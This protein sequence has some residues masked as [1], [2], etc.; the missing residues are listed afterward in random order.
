MFSLAATQTP[1]DTLTNN[2]YRNTL[3]ILEENFYH[4]EF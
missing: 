1:E 3:V 4:V 2:T